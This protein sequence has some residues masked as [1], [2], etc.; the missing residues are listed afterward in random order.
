MTKKHFIELADKVRS[1]E[2]IDGTVDFDTLKRK[3]ADFC[4]DQNPAFDRGR[5]FGYINGDC[6]PSGGTIKKP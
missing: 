4:K 6:G 3:L 5:W 2:V 1:L